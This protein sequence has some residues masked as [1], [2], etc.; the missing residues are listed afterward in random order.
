[1]RLRRRYSEAS[2][3][4]K[5]VLFGEHFVVYGNPAIL[6][7]IDKRVHAKIQVSSGEEITI[8]SGQ[9]LVGPAGSERII[10][11]QNS[12]EPKQL[13]EP[14][15]ECAKA[16]LSERDSKI[17]LNIEL[18]SYFPMGIGLGSSAACCV[19]I[20]GAVDSLFHQ[21]TKKWICMKAT[22]SERRIHHNSSGADCNICT[23]GGIMYYTKRNG[24]R[25]IRVKE[26]LPLALLNTKERHSTGE[27]VSSVKNYRDSNYQAF[28]V[29]AGSSKIISKKAVNAIKQNDYRRIGGL[30]NQNQTLL[31]EI[32]VSTRKIQRLIDLCLKKGALGA[33][34]TGAGGGGCVIS[35]FPPEKHST[36]FRWIENNLKTCEPF[37]SKIDY[38]GVLIH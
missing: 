21:P 22:E 7:A 17:G 15:V 5:V 31:Q 26:D 32:G 13:L 8:L 29:L 10:K 25:R 11:T 16:V 37:P 36:F 14:L 33:K 2:A 38:E 20:T 9:K 18:N 19:A 1:M 34:L 24:F 35:L 3:P 12:P 27:L 23:Y 28:K 6:A 4:G 30:M